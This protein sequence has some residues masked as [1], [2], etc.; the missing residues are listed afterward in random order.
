VIT[1][2]SVTAPVREAIRRAA[3]R[4]VRVRLVALRLVAPLRTEALAEALAG[5]TRVMVVEQNHG[6]QF[7]RYLRSVFDLPARQT[8][9]H[10][11]G[12]LPLRPA[13]LADAIAE[14]STAP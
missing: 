4:G 8:S 13:E 6:A 7:H 2:G 5:V 10:R 1:F 9:F 11:P 14:W 12:P 3:L